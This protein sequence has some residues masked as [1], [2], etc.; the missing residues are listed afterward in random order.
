MTV[1]KTVSIILPKG[2]NL[3]VGQSHFIKMAEDL[4]YT[5]YSSRLSIKL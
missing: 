4:Y 5:C 1:P 2:V 3:I